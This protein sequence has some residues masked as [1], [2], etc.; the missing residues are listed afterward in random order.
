LANVENAATD[1]HGF[2]WIEE[3]KKKDFN[4][5]ESVKSVA[6]VSPTTND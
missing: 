6:E 5:C 4:P 3:Q 2:T 1:F